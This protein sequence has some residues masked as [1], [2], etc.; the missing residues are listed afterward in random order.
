MNNISNKR[1]N[2]IGLMVAVLN[3]FGLLLVYGCATSNMV[4]SAKNMVWGKSGKSLDAL[5]NEHPLVE[6]D[7]IKWYLDDTVTPTEVMLKFTCVTASKEWT[8]TTWADM[9]E[10]NFDESYQYAI[11][12][13]ASK[14]VRYEIIFVVGSQIV[15]V[16]RF[17]MNDKILIEPAFFNKFIAN[18]ERPEKDYIAFYSDPLSIPIIYL[19]QEN[20]F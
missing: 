10:V 4:D 1:K 7:S 17:I 3:I 6:K 19:Q 16:P 8:D 18:L 20:Y 15:K 11:Q 2:N 14:P 13:F 12:E 5:L 9:A